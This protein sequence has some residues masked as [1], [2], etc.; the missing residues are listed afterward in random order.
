MP[1]EASAE[2]GIALADRLA[3]LSEDEQNEMLVDLVIAEAMIAR[4]DTTAGSLNRDSPFFDVGFNSLSAVEL[5]NRLNDATGLK[6]PPMLAFDYPT[7]ALLAE[8]L[9]SLLDTSKVVA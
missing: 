7:P 4:G 1:E 6:L 2:D 9:R 5:R 3:G 8:E